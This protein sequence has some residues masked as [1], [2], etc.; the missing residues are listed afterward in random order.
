[1]KTNSIGKV[2]LFGQIGLKAGFLLKS[3]DNYTVENYS[4]IG[5]PLPVEYSR[6]NIDIYS[7][8]DFIRLALVVG[9]GVEYNLIGNTC[10]QFS[11]NYDNGFTNLNNTSSSQVLSKGVSATIGVLF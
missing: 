1:M 2:R 4:I 3:T 11:L 7:Q 10:F 8:T 9:L 6:S 5:P